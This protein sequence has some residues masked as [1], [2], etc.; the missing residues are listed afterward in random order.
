M[1]IASIAGEKRVFTLQEARDLV[2]LL[3]KV[4]AD[5]VGMVNSLLAK[6]ECLSEDDT[7]FDE[8]RGSIDATVRAWAEKLQ[9]LGCEVKGLW[10][11]DFDNG[12]G[13][14]CWSFPED[15]LDHFHSYEEGATERKRIC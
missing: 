3:R 13:Y 1:S 12:Q 10:L 15:E 8:L 4:T 2:P 6:L 11:V 9:K 5:A 7:E 14:Y